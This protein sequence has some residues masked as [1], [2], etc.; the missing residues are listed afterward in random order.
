MPVRRR[1]VVRRRGGALRDKLKKYGPYLAA[2]LTGLAAPHLAKGAHAGF[3]EAHADLMHELGKGRRRRRRRV[4][5]GRRRARGAQAPRPGVALVRRRRV[6]GRGPRL[7]KLKRIA[8]I[9]LPIAGALAYGTYNAYQDKF[10]GPHTLPA[11]RTFHEHY[12]V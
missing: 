12:R 5:G 9:A 11:P 8:K 3:K 4:A 1:R 7:D 10:H 2:A 6:V